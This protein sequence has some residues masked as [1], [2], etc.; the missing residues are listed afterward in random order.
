MVS[1]LEDGGNKRP[2]PVPVGL[3][4]LPAPRFCLS[5]GGLPTLTC[6]APGV[7]HAVRELQDSSS[8]SPSSL[9]PGLPSQLGHVPP[10]LEARCTQH[11]L[12]IWSRRC[13]E[14]WYHP[15]PGGDPLK[16]LLVV[17][18]VDLQTEMS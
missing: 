6:V 11:T 14:T 18:V 1:D 9:V 13:Q 5:D 16:A 17:M 15:P 12:I 2:L 3:A 4:L 7:S 8:L 10:P